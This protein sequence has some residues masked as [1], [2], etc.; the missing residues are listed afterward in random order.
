[1]QDRKRD[2]CARTV[3]DCG[4]GLRGEH[5]ENGIEKIYNIVCETEKKEK[6]KVK[7]RNGKFCSSLI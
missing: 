7:G 4:R 3:F 2:R 6:E 5:W 1:M